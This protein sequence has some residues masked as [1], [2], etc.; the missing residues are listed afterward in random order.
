MGNNPLRTLGF[1]RGT[2][3]LICREKKEIIPV[4]FRAAGADVCWSPL[5]SQQFCCQKSLSKDKLEKLVTYFWI[6][7]VRNL[8]FILMHLSSQS[9]FCEHHLLEW[10]VCKK[11]K[12]LCPNKN[13]LTTQL[14]H[15]RA[16]LL[17]SQ[18]SG[19]AP[20]HYLKLKKRSCPAL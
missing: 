8:D 15:E 12:I 18:I 14:Q 7:D 16:T 19:L 10:H 9:S 5:M 2:E 11:E 1:T 20:V 3:G 17:S 6:L 4:A 13:F